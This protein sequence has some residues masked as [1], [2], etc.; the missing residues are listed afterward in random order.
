MLSKNDKRRWAVMN[1]KATVDEIVKSSDWFRRSEIA[2][3]AMSTIHDLGSDGEVYFAM[4]EEYL[5]TKY[6][7]LGVYR[8]KLNEIVDSEIYDER[9]QKAEEFI[10]W[11]HTIGLL[12]E[13]E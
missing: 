8:E 3:R 1:L 10:E 6:K 12:L 7:S 11:C 9:E 5:V 4:K 2:T 13:N